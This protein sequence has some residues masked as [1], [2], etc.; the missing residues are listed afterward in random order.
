MAIVKVNRA[1][2]EQAIAETDWAAQDALTDED[3]ERQVAGNPDAAPILTAAQTVAAMARTIR[4]RLDLSQEEF[5]ALYDI[6]VG[7]LRDWEQARKQPDRTA[8]AYLRVIAKEPLLVAQ[9]LGTMSPA[10]VP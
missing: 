8:L 2:A 4:K 6:P 3:I 9:A 7:T 5:A 1:V 10:E